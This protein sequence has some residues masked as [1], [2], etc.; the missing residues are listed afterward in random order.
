MLDFIDKRSR[1]GRRLALPAL[2]IVIEYMV[3]SVEVG[4]AVADSRTVF[5]VS[6]N[7]H[8]PRQV[9]TFRSRSILGMTERFITLDGDAEIKRFLERTGLFAYPSSRSGP[10]KLYRSSIEWLQ[11]TISDVRKGGDPRRLF[12]DYY[13]GGAPG[14]VLADDPV[15]VLKKQEAK[16]WLVCKP[17][18]MLD[19]MA[20]QCVVDQ[21]R[22]HTVVVCARK[23]CK[24]EFMSKRRD[25]RFC[26]HRCARKARA[27]SPVSP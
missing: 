8:A 23:G 25:H 9:D 21:L 15:F 22:G 6:R 19:A 26:G 12:R 27:A 1:V 11:E 2:P 20:A 17:R 16:W 24:N 4:V 7:A 13:K 18:T 10:L 3:A 5:T 14:D